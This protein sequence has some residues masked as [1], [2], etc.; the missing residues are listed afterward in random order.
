MPFLASSLSSLKTDVPNLSQRCRWGCRLA[1]P[2]RVKVASLEVW[3]SVKVREGWHPSS[4]AQKQH[5][6]I[7][8][9][10]CSY[11]TYIYNIYIYIICI[12]IFLLQWFK[13]SVWFYQ[14]FV[15]TSPF[16]LQLTPSFA[17]NSSILTMKI[18]AC[19]AAMI[20]R[21]SWLPGTVRVAGSKAASA[22]D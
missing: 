20:W 8:Q 17:P 1:S 14:G 22:N 16:I 2:C 19:K 9:R 4:E 18:Q 6:F 10:V 5:K 15:T 7:W 21:H 13:F 11:M 3:R 12:Y